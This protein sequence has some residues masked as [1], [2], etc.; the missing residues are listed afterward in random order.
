MD[1]SDQLVFG[2]KDELLCLLEDALVFRE[3]DDGMFL[4]N[5]LAFAWSRFVFAAWAAACSSELVS[6]DITI[7][8]LVFELTLCWPLLER[9]KRLL[10]VVSLKLDSSV[11]K[12]VGPQN[13]IEITIPEY[14]ETLVREILLPPES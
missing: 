9:R 5:S 8:M 12:S 10:E 6:T 11:F 2:D 13:K 14:T 4:S 3:D 1:P 7:G